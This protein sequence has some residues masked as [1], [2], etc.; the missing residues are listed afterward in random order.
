MGTVLIRHLWKSDFS[1]ASGDSG[2]PMTE[3]CAGAMGVL[4]TT[5]GSYSTIDWIE[6]EAGMRPCYSATCS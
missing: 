6:S 3:C 5:Q 4:S 2:G 1:S